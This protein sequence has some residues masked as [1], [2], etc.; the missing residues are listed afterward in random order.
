MSTRRQAAPF[1]SALRTTSPLQKARLQTLKTCWSVVPM[2]EIDIWWGPRT[3]DLHTRYHWSSKVWL[4]KAQQ[5]IETATEPQSTCYLLSPTHGD[6]SCSPAAH[7]I[8]RRHSNESVWTS[9]WSSLAKPQISHQKVAIC[10]APF[11]SLY[12]SMYLSIPSDRI[13]TYPDLSYLIL[14]YPKNLIL[15]IY[16]RK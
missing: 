14:S 2:G 12:L 4:F 13:L 8:T 7:V 9:S 15:S 10:L 1:G 6:Q 16:S 11:T 5:R 3:K